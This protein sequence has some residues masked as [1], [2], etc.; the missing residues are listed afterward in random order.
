M[1]ERSHSSRASRRSSGIYAIQFDGTGERRL[2][3]S[4]IDSQFDLAEWSPDGDTLVFGAAM[5]DEADENLWAVGLD[6][7]PERRIVGSPGDDMGPTW[8]PDGQRSPI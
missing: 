5:V 7:K 1:V 4:Q 3:L 2:T 8:S 6:G